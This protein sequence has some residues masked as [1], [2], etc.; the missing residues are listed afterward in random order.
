MLAT[1]VRAGP[2]FRRKRHR[3]ARRGRGPGHQHVRGRDGG[4]PP[5]ARHRPRRLPLRPRG[6]DSSTPLEETVAG[7]LPPSSPRAGPGRGLPRGPSGLLRRARDFAAEEG[8]PRTASSSSA[9][10]ICAPGPAPTSGCRSTRQRPARLR[11]GPARPEPARLLR[12]AQSART[13]GRTGPS[14]EPRPADAG[15]RLAV[16]HRSPPRPGDTEPGRPVL[17]AGRRTA[18][19]A[20]PRCRSVGRLGE[21]LAAIDLKLEP[22][23]RERL[24][25]GSA[26]CLAHGVDQVVAVVD[27]LG[28]LDAVQG[29]LVAHGVDQPSERRRYGSARAGS[30]PGQRA[31]QRPPARTARARLASGRNSPRPQAV[32]HRVAECTSAKSR[33]AGH[34]PAAPVSRWK[35]P[36]TIVSGSPQSS[37][38]SQR[39]N[40]SVAAARSS[41]VSPG[42]WARAAGPYRWSLECAGPAARRAGARARPARRRN[43]RRRG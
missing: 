13:P 34:P 10:P 1:R 20:D 7:L 9:T 16:L 3:L 12:P 11:R 27:P 30:A 41:A 22:E 42:R 35:S 31:V 17:A 39:P 5:P 28:R 36:C 37:S 6:S 14:G 2:S 25:G 19:H 43:G 38:A 23:L 29:P 4:G 26:E 32:E 15:E 33:T 40:R 18:G 21:C 24:A 8:R